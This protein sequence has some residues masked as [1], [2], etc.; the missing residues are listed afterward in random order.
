MA[1]IRINYDEVRAAA[2][3]FD[4]Q[5]ETAE[6]L[7]LTLSQRT[8]Q[9][10]SSWDGAAQQAFAQDMAACRQLL[11]QVPDMLKQIA[12]ALRSTADTIEA[13]E[14]ASINALGKNSP[15]DNL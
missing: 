4:Q 9:L 10:V 6:Q 5:A 8:E 1:E 13:A 7:V 2:T 15:L 3:D 11:G 14:Q 12:H